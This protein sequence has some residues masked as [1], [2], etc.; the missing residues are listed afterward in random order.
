MLCVPASRQAG[1]R[2]CLPVC[3]TQ[4][5]VILKINGLLRIMP[6]LNEMNLPNT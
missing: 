1:L 5:D 2:Q 3:N 4:T 6:E